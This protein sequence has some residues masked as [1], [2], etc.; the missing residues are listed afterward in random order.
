P[1]LCRARGY[2]TA[3][4]GK[5]H[6][7]LPPAFHPAR[8][9]FDEFF[10]IPY[11]NDNGP[12]HPVVRGIP[13]LPLYD[14]ERVVETD[15]DQSLFTRRFTDRAVDFIRRHKDRPFFLYLPHVMPH[16]PLF[17]S[18][19]F[20][21]R[22]KGGLYGDV[23]EELDAGVGEVLDALRAHGLEERTIVVFISDNGPFLSYGTHAGSAK[24]LREGKLTTFDGGLRVPCL[25]RWPG[26]IPAGRVCAEPL[27]SMDLLPTFAR[28][29]GAPPGRPVDGRDVG[30]V[31]KGRPGARSPH[32]AIFFYAGEELQAVRSGPWKLHV[33]HDYLTV[34]GPTRTDGKPANFENMKPAGMSE[35]GVRGIASRHGYR[36]ERTPRAL[37]NLP[38]DPSESKDV[39]A[40][41]PD[42]VA[43]LEALLEKARADLGDVLTKRR[44]SGV[45]P[46]GRM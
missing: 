12:L 22:S 8:H 23:V 16:V 31:L 6:L 26:R 30:D 20:R 40:A 44:G 36:V 24:P 38:D 15:P 11:S 46:A 4:Y 27:T 19:A 18:A 33:E 34:A 43:R 14:G 21:G 2:A 37:Y 9:G 3:I 29:I 7:G 10:G 45:R 13:P 1:E 32:E 25:V 39:S 5:W 41:H 42:V 35:S 17:A 28:W